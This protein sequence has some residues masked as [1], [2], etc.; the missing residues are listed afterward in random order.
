MEDCPTDGG[1]NTGSVDVTGDGNVV[2]GDDAACVRGRD[3]VGAPR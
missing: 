3:D 2:A 1:R